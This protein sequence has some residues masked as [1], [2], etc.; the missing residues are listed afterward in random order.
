MQVQG[1]VQT[2]LWPVRLM[3]LQTRLSRWESGTQ[4]QRQP[5][6]QQ[7]WPLRSATLRHRCPLQQQRRQLSAQQCEPRN[8]RLHHLTTTKRKRR[9]LALQALV[10]SLLVL[11]VLQVPLGQAQQGLQ[12]LQQQAQLLALLLRLPTAPP[13]L[14]RRAERRIQWRLAQALQQPLLV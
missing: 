8:C 12:V 7:H 13:A 1:L 11:Q 2:R 4:Q 10:H 6:G 14:L 3:R 9:E 5:E